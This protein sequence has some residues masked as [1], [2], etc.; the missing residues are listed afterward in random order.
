MGNIICC[1]QDSNSQ[2][3]DTHKFSK[4]DFMRVKQYNIRDDYQIDRQLGLGSYGEVRLGL[5]KKTQIQVAIKKIPVKPDDKELLDMIFKEVEILIQ[6]DHPN[7]IR[8]YDVFKEPRVTYIVEEFID[9]CT[10]ISTL[11]KKEVNFNEQHRAIV[12]E[13][14]LRALNYMHTNKLVHRDLKTE[15]VVYAPNKN[16]GGDF[17]SLEVKL[18]DFGFANANNNKL[19]EF[20]G[21]PYYVAP[22]IINREKYGSACDI[23]SLGVMTYL[24]IDGNYPFNASNQEELFAK[25]TS[26]QAPSYSGAAWAVVSEPC[27]QF[28]QAC[29]TF[30]QGKRPSASKLLNH[31]WVMLNRPGEGGEPKLAMQ[32]KLS[33]KI[34]ANIVT[35]KVATEYE[36]AIIQYMNQLNINKNETDNLRKLFE[37]VDDDKNGTLSF[38]EIKKILKQHLS[39]EDYDEF[40]KLIK[41]KLDS[42]SNGRIDYSEFLDLTVEHKKLLSRFNLEITFNN[43]DVDNS[44]FLTIDELKKTFEAAGN[45]KS[46]QFW[47]QFMA[48]VDKNGDGEIHLEE[49]ISAMEKLIK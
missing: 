39:S 24:L 20:V 44:G 26:K 18:I 9:G 5:N 29:L 30:D 3:A 7:I 32:K 47:D 36:W 35:S 14:V 23:W 2:G 11:F 41:D 40:V 22:E 42:N 34:A 17:D 27:K 33:S 8:V 16:D 28:V 25:I 38:D 1:A 12:I 13:Q 4:K 31:D 6:C 45:K 37:A 46:Q 49:F 19:T 48:G 43:L 21:T 15:N 10:P